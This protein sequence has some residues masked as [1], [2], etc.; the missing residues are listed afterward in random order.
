[1]S[2]YTYEPRTR[3]QFHRD[4][5]AQKL[6]RQFMKNGGEG[7]GLGVSDSFR[8]GYTYAFELSDSQRAAVDRLMEDYA[9]L[10]LGSA[11][12]LVLQSEME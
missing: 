10:D 4:P 8:D 1:M 9:G 3:E 11:L 12:R 2:K 6:L 5:K 7:G